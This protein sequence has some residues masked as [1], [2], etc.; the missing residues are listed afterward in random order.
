MDRD[1][2][3]IP[4]QYIKGV[5]PQRTKLLTRLSI[6]TAADALSYL[7]LRYEDRRTIKKL[8]ALTYG[9]KETAV[10]KIVALD[11]IHLPR[12]RS[13]LF[14]L[15]I[16]DGTG[17]L[18]G[19]WFNQPYM[20]KLFRIGQEV[21]LSGIVKQNSY[22]GTGLEMDNPEHEF[23]DT[24]ADN[25]I[26]T[27]RIVPI[28][29][30]TAGLSVRVLRAIVFNALSACLEQ[31]RD[32]IPM[33]I[34]SR[35]RLPELRESIANVHFPPPESDIEALN[36]GTSCYHRRLCFDELLNLEIGIAV[37]KKKKSRAPGI[38]FN[39]RG[40]LVGRLMEKLSFRPTVAQER[41]FHEILHGMKQPHPMNRLLQGDVGCGKT[42]VALMAMLTAVECGY[43]VALM[44]PTEI[45]AEQHFIT[46]HNLVEDLG[47]TISL[48]TSARKE[49]P[50]AEIASG[51]IDIVVG[52]HALIQEGIR[53]RKLGLVVIDEQHRFGVMQRAAL[54]KKAHN[55]DVLVM[56]ATPIPRT[57]AM[58]VYGD[59]DYSV[60]DELPPRRSP[61]RTQRYTS[62][63]KN[64]IYEAISSEVRKSRQVY[65]VY[66][67]I[68]ESEN[69]DLKSAIT[70]KA[71]LEMIFP[72]FRIGL[73]HGKMKTAEREAVMTA[74]KDS[75]IDILVSTTV[76]EVGVDIPNATM[77]LIVHAERFGLSQLHQLRGR[78]GRGSDQ[79]HCL[80]LAYEPCSDEG[81]KRLDIMMK[82]NDGF[83]IAEED[84]AIRGPGEFLG[85][86]Q[87]GL[88]DLKIADI[89]RD[90]KL[91]ESARREAAQ[92]VS[93]DPA[94]E[95]SPGL[96]WAVEAF[97][98]EKIEMF[99]TS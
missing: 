80:L 11:V 84:L 90:A 52:T 14:E 4:I 10:G 89:I 75:G 29:R 81:R 95:K 91:L 16:S 78:V 13:K 15:V 88:P 70:G 36:G 59:L 74:F 55:P 35:N 51:E 94:L 32:P 44:A 65:V 83:R 47:L 49:K 34:L 31:V 87:S 77:M 21:I 20:K 68:E 26:H 38:A 50:K 6:Q 18:K 1:P 93:D 76:I 37:M 64:L 96:K 48:L 60:I 46:I 17:L 57:L 97:W 28:Y 63:Q 5:G 73:V 2:S 8:H 58:T 27:S 19:K 25:L 23:I 61:V 42:I 66:P 85:T 12:S 86:R 30:T 39:P 45:L 9:Q 69:S 72:D 98:H 24:D 99:K 43:Q 40:E 56:T 3:E 71:A 82:S 41:V 92:I 54:R 53:F 33:E 22:R 79:S 67:V 62:R 7:P